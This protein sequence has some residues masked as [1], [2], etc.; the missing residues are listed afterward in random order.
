VLPFLLLDV[1]LFI[2]KGVNTEEEQ[3]VELD[4]KDDD[5]TVCA[6]AYC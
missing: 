3:E 4:E 6:T 5:N 2:G 1:S